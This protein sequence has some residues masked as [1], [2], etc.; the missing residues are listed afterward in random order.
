MTPNIVTVTVT[1][2]KIAPGAV[3]TP[4]FYEIPAGHDGWLPGTG[5]ANMVVQGQDLSA[6]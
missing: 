4:T 1:A 6:I 3:L 5:N 2:S